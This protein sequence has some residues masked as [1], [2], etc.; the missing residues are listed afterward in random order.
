VREESED[1][2]APSAAAEPA[3]ARREVGRDGPHVTARPILS[4]FRS[5]LS[6][7]LR[8]LRS[9]AWQK[10][11]EAHLAEEEEGRTARKANLRRPSAARV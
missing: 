9:R 11:E 5:S 1:E 7:G 6:I 3:L 8:A 2:A 4:R 10:S